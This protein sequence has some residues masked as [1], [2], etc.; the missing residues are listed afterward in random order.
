MTPVVDLI[1]AIVAGMKPTISPASGALTGTGLTVTYSTQPKSVINSLFVGMKVKLTFSGTTVYAPIT[2]VGT[3]SFIATLPAVQTVAPTAVSVVLNFHH[4]HPEEIINLFKQA[5]HKESVK[6]EQ[7]PAICLFQDI[8]EKHSTVKE[9]EATLNMVIITDTKKEYEASQRYTYTFRP[10]LIP[11]FTRLIKA[12]ECSGNI[13]I[14]S[15]DFEY[16]ERLYWGK[17]GLYGNVGNIFNDF[18]D[19]IE[20]NNLRIKILKDN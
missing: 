3:S 19:A 14:V 11:L 15:E 2:T 1:S 16:Y 12:I 18:I 20:L 9:R 8:P 13:G 7:F 6:R 10:I 5:T 4:G 17:S